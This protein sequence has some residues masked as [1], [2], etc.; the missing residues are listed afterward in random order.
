[1][2]KQIELLLR[3]HVENLGRCGDIVSVRGGYAWNFLLPQKLAV[4]ATSENRRVIA[5]RATRVDA[6]ESIQREALAGIAEAINNLTVTTLQKTDYGGHLYG[7]VNAA[8]VA[9]LCAA[10]NVIVDE[11]K[12]RLAHPIKEVG[13]H[14]V[15]VHLFAGLIATMTVVVESENPAPAPEPVREEPQSEDSEGGSDDAPDGDAPKEG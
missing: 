3:D 14:E 2:G 9:E 1:M 15:P 13:T 8:Q 6:E 12:I 7:S 11:S 4:F 10:A 5:R